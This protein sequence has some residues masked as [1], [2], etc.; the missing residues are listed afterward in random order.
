MK[1]ILRILLGTLVFILYAVPCLAA[2]RFSDP[3][4]LGR[5]A[6]SQDWGGFVVVNADWVNAS[7]WPKPSG[8]H[9]EETHYKE[10]LAKFSHGRD[11]IFAHFSDAGS[12]QLL[13]GSEDGQNTIG[14]ASFWGSE[15]V[16]VGTNAPLTVFAS[17]EGNSF[18]CNFLF[19]ARLEDGS[20]E[21]FFNTSE[22]AE[23][24]TQEYKAANPGNPAVFAFA[25]NL[26]V[27]GDTIIAFCRRFDA[28]HYK[29]GVP[30]CK[31]R[32]KWNEEK[33][34]FDTEIVWEGQN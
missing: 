27:E 31:C 25:R 23:P 13:W 32:F 34:G 10:G 15:L 28:A 14:A 24:L 16:K 9:S 4:E 18:G 2:M 20:Y 1:N 21:K 29:D 17:R 30:A 7:E 5:V 3:Q 26:E 19:F 33:Q 11:T 6:W 22:V 8:V 12:G